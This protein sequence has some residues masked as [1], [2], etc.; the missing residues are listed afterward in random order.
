MNS[1]NNIPTVTKYLTIF[2]G[3]TAV[4]KKS[5]NIV[6]VMNNGGVTYTSTCGTLPAAETMKCYSLSWAVTNNG[7]SSSQAWDNHTSIQKISSA[8]FSGAIY[9]IE[10]SIYDSSVIVTKLSNIIALKNVLF[11]LTAF[12]NSSADF[13][14]VGFTFK[15]VDSIALNFYLSTTEVSGISSIRIYPVEVACT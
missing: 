4:L 1:I 10:T 6:S 15:S 11:S 3:Q 13:F 12:S 14:S 7:D 2:P 9:P 8:V 5:S